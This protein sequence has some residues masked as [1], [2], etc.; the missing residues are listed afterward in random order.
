MISCIYAIFNIANDKCYV[1]QAANKQKR[2][3]NHRVALRVNNHNNK[4]LQ[5]AYNKHGDAAFIYVMLEV[6]EKHNLTECE[7]YWM[8]ALKP[9]YNKAPAAGSPL[10]FKHSEETRAKLSAIRKGK[11]RSEE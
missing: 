7:Q 2:W 10:G 1:G 9:E 3:K 5:A 4:H 6:C 11:K 8:D